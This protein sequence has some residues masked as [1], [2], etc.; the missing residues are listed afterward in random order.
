MMVM[1]LAMAAIYSVF[2]MSIRVFMFGNDKVEAV[3]SARLGLEKMERDIRAAHPFNGSD[4]S[5][6]NDHLF[7]DPGNAGTG[8]MPVSDR[9]SFGNDLGSIA[10]GKIDCPN[11]D[12]R[13]EY[14][15]YRLT[16]ANSSRAC[17]GANAPC[18]LRRV[19]TANFA[20][21]GEPVV[22]FVQPGGLT[23]TYLKADGT[24]A[25]NESEVDRVQVRLQV[26]VDGRVQSLTTSVDL[27]N[28]THAGS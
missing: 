6:E 11:P 15:T 5:A 13:C 24:P 8:A 21:V 19:N 7:F 17:T 3:E 28:R 18:V 14:V 4:A 25:E 9:I 10:D 1:L 27:R 26:D 20:N 16:A 23:F 22:D 12:G 2:D